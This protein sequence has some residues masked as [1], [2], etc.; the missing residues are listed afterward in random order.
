[1][2][3]NVSGGIIVLGMILQS[4]QDNDIAGNVQKNSAFNHSGPEFAKAV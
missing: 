2:S 1:M 4:L 3:R